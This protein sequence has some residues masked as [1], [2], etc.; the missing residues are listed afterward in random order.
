MQDVGHER[1][2][3]GVI[4]GRQVERRL[5][6]GQ[7]GGGATE[8]QA[9]AGGRQQRLQDLVGIVDQEGL[10]V[11][12]RRGVEELRAVDRENIGKLGAADRNQ[13]ERIGA[14]NLRQIG[15]DL[16]DDLV[17]LIE[18]RR[19]GAGH[20]IELLPGRIGLRAEGRIRDR[21]NGEPPGL[22][23]VERLQVRHHAVDG[24]GDVAVDHRL[25]LVVDVRRQHEQAGDVDGSADLAQHRQV[26]VGRKREAA[27]ALERPA[28]Q[29]VADRET[30]PGR[31]WIIKVGEQRLAD[32]LLEIA[33]EHRL[34]RRHRR[35]VDR[36]RGVDGRG[37]IDL[38][39]G[40]GFR[41]DRI[42]G[43]ATTVRCEEEPGADAFL[44]QVGDAAKRN[45]GT[46]CDV[47]LLRVGGVGQC[48]RID[49]IP[50]GGGV[51]LSG[52]REA[53]HRRAQPGITQTAIDRCALE[54]QQRGLDGAGIPGPDPRIRTAEA[55]GSA[56]EQCR[57]RKILAAEAGQRI[58]Q[59]IDIGGADRDAV[60]GG[61]EG[62]H[63]GGFGNQILNF[64]EFL[65]RRGHKIV[66]GIGLHLA[67]EGLQR[68]QSGIFFLGQQILEGIHHVLLDGAGE[69]ARGALG[70]TENGV[71]K[72]GERVRRR[73]GVLLDEAG[74]G[75]GRHRL[76]LR[77]QVG[78]RRLQVGSAHVGDLGGDHI[79]IVQRHIAELA[80]NP[81]D[82]TVD[83]VADRRRH[84][85]GDR[86]DQRRQGILCVSTDSRL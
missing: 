65:L 32:A 71:A 13:P 46:R 47:L 9:L 48:D 7:Q 53:I 61:G 1:L 29:L 3:G 64:G 49:E 86:G 78:E 54:V 5:Q 59:L 70:L 50:A 12:D 35:A 57:A 84:G 83:E 55:G 11:V 19:V 8:Q 14:G 38:G 75:V 85:G 21:G 22:I 33:V 68:R 44:D 26:D 4:A 60:H 25:E 69:C 31:G 40:G 80:D 18:L 27:A 58:H 30:A 67:D 34:D 42:V 74:D 45:P 73:L 76:D 37:G 17:G 66:D 81:I 36:R 28:R 77:D 51:F 72:L 6:H 52:Q 10:E 23:E 62:R 41:V 56:G 39:G 15:L 16:V 82:H 20:A 43:E 24:A 2:K 63:C 79:D